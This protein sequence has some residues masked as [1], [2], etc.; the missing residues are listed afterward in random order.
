MEE[1][2]IDDDHL[3]RSADAAMGAVFG[4][5]SKKVGEWLS[6]DCNCCVQYSA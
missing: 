1:L 2:M 4:D 6:L 3:Q 5:V